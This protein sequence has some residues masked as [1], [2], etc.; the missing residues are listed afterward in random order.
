VA[1]VTRLQQPNEG[2]F[3]AEADQRG[4]SGSEAVLGSV[5]LGHPPLGELGAEKV[6]QFAVAI[7]LAVK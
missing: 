7:R 6:D 4:A 3:A 5:T 2:R 1:V